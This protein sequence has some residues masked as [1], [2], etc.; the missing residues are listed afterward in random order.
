LIN[1]D[2]FTAPISIA[3]F[4]KLKQQKNLEILKLM[5]E[6]KIELAGA[7]SEIKISGKLEQ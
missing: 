2:F 6:M 3:E 7:S 5:E 1:A 4:N